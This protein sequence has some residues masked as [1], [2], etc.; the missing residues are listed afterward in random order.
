MSKSDSCLDH[1]TCNTNVT[2]EAGITADSVNKT[3]PIVARILTNQTEQSYGDVFN[4]RNTSHDEQ[5]DQTNGTT[6]ITPFTTDL[7]PKDTW[8]EPDMA[9]DQCVSSDTIYN[10]DV[11]ISVVDKITQEENVETATLKSLVTYIGVSSKKPTSSP[12]AGYSRQQYRPSIILVN[13]E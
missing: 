4:R 8:V 10:E 13:G 9:L 12:S 6:C 11:V 3:K 5:G 7:K 1:I 2:R